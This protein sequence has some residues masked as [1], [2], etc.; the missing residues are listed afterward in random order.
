[1]AAASCEKLENVSCQFLS[2]RQSYRAE[3]SPRLPDARVSLITA[4][5]VR[6]LAA[7]L[8][9]LRILTPLDRAALA[10]Y[11]NAYGL[12]A[13]ATQ[14]IQKY[15]TMVESPSGYPIQSPTSRLPTAKPRS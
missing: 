6:C 11:C 5:F 10:A 12:W 13:E 1:M 4:D 2:L 3:R 15:G 14:A 9:I 8:G 7:E